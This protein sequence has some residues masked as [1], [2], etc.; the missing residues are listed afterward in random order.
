MEKKK[1]IMISI[2]ARLGMKVSLFAAC[3]VIAP[4][5]TFWI[6]EPEEPAEMRARL[7]EMKM[8]KE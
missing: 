4:L 2:V 1:R 3:I 7:A 6:F 8:E 5:C